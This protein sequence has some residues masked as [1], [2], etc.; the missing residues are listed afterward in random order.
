MAC[1]PPTRK[2]RLTPQMR[3]AARILGGIFPPLPGGVTM[4][5]S[6]TP[7]SLAGM[8]FMMTL[9]GYAAVPPGT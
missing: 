7:A 1:A 4:T 6:L 2:T 5:I 8:Q 9:E 3:A